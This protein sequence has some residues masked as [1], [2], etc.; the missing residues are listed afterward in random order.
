VVRTTGGG[1][2]RGVLGAAAGAEHLAQVHQVAHRRAAGHVGLDLGDQEGRRRGAHQGQA[3][4]GEV[5]AVLAPPPQVLDEAPRPV[6]GGG[7]ALGR[8]QV[9]MPLLGCEFE[10]GIVLGRTSAPVGS[11]AAVAGGQGQQEQDRERVE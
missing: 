8:R 9:A 2:H 11:G 3:L 7:L 4:L 5:E 1:E 6:L 10:H